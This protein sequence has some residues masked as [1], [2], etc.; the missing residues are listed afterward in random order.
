MWRY[1][2]LTVQGRK[3]VMWWKWI[4][5][6]ESGFSKWG[7]EK[8]EVAESIT[9]EDRSTMKKNGEREV[10][11]GRRR[12]EIW[13][14]SRNSA[15]A[16]WRVGIESVNRIGEEWTNAGQGACSVDWITNWDRWHGGRIGAA[17]W[18]CRPNA[19]CTIGHSSVSTR[20]VSSNRGRENCFSWWWSSNGIIQYV[21]LWNIEE[22]Y[23][24]TKKAFFIWPHIACI[25]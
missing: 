12:K 5:Y 22:Y 23:A 8:T 15:K 13:N 21:V 25:H 2:Q 18:R 24:N 20:R 17:E 16:S 11:V 9:E 3:E 14:S 19:K 1:D 6:N 4:L 10:E 7:K